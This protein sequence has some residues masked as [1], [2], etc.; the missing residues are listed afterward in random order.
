MVA[1]ATWTWWIGF[2][3]VLLLLLVAE[4]VFAHRKQGSQRSIWIVPILLIACATAF[5][6]W[7]W[8]T[9]GRSP[10]LEFV[11]GYTIELSLSI[12]NLFVFLVLL[13]GFGISPARQQKALLWGVGGAIVLRALFII[14][15]VTLLQ[16]F[17]WI[18]W[19]FGAF[20]IYA[21]WKL[22]RERSPRA[23]IPAWIQNMH[24]A[25]GSLLPVILAIELTDLLFATDSV[26]AV[27]SVTRDPFI[28]YTSNI[29][30]ILGLRSLYVALADLLERVRFLN[31]TLAILLGFVGLKMLASPWFDIPVT[32]SLAVIGAVLAACAIANAVL[33]KSP[34][35]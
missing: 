4:A 10:A 18:T 11:A 2:H 30:A 22:A 14:V 1:G 13:Q 24:S 7:I 27:L 25:K 20:L 21:A 19:L 15:G 5:A 16:H 17:E 26:P 29:A 35:S 12:D 31:T 9:R 8:F 6:I 23:A 32:I 28:A 34:R 33:P 3:A